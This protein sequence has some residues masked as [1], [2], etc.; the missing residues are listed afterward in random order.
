MGV[1][2]AILAKVSVSKVENKNT[3]VEKIKG[4]NSIKVWGGL[5]FY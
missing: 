4:K 1:G 2:E 5:D 3:K